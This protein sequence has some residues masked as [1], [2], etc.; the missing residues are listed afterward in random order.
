M[1]ITFVLDELVRT[2]NPLGL[3][4]L[5]AVEG[6]RVNA[7]VGQYLLEEPAQHKY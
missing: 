7:P 1:A 2:V 5:Q 6:L 4:C 3:L